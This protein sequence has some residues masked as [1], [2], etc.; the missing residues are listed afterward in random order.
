MRL[1]HDQQ[2][3]MNLLKRMNTQHKL[4][5]QVDYSL[6]EDLQRALERLQ[7]KDWIRLIDVATIEA[8]CGKLM[9]IFLVMPPAVAWYEQIVAQQRENEKKI[10]HQTILSM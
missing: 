4:G 3:E 8:S 2:C 10:A 5:I 9:R 1:P 7:L 6:S